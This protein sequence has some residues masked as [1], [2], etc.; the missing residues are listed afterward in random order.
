MYYKFM[1][2]PKQKRV[3]DYI[4]VCLE[5]QGYPPTIREIARN[6]SISIGT[7][8]WY[9]KKLQE[10]GHLD[11]E[12][13]TARSLVLSQKTKGIPIVGRIAAGQ[14]ILAVQDVEGY[15]PVSE[16]SGNASDLFA[17]RVKGDSMIEAGILDGDIVILRQQ[18]TA[19]NGDIVA[20]LLEEETT[21]K[22]LRKTKNGY[23]LQSE[24]PKYKSIVSKSFYI[25]GKT[26][27]VVRSYK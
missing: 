6:L 14:P 26:I 24:N 11:R 12:A 8:Q 9:L 17:L 5:E 22:R 10:L 7:V 23:V 16:Y 20:A 13:G 1:L 3:L 27:K 2:G 18:Q 19:H 25:L 21:L 15:I 4:N